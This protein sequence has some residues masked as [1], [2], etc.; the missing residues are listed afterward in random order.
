VISCDFGAFTHCGYVLTGMP[1]AQLVLLNSDKQQIGKDGLAPKRGDIVYIQGDNSQNMRDTMFAPAD[2][3][4]IITKGTAS[5]LRTFWKD[6]NPNKLTTELCID[7]AAGCGKSCAVKIL[8]AD[9][10][11]RLPETQVFYWRGTAASHLSIVHNKI[12]VVDKDT[13]LFFDQITDSTLARELS[14]FADRPSVR[15]VLV[16]SANLAHFA[17]HRE[18]RQHDK[19][20]HSFEFS[21]DAT[22]C[23]RYLS[24]MSP[25]SP[26]VVAKFQSVEVLGFSSRELPLPA[27]DDY[28]AVCCWTNGHLLSISQIVRGVTT[29]ETLLNERMN[30]MSDFMGQDSH[31]DFCLALLKMFRNG[32]TTLDAYIGS[33]DRRYVSPQRHVL[34][35]LFL[36]A[37]EHAL[38]VGSTKENL[39]ISNFFNASHMTLLNENPSVI[40]FAVERECLMDANLLRVAAGCLA[41][42]DIIV[43]R[44]VKC[45]RIGFRRYDQICDAA[46]KLGAGNWALHAIP[47]QWNEKSVDGVQLYSL[48]NNLYIIGN[49]ITLQTAQDH[50]HSVKWV[51]TA[52][53]M[54]TQLQTMFATVTSGLVFTAKQADDFTDLRI[55]DDDLLTRCAQFTV[56]DFPVMTLISAATAAYN[57]MDQKMT[58]VLAGCLWS[59]PRRGKLRGVVA[60]GAVGQLDAVATKPQ[61]NVH[62]IATMA[63]RVRTVRTSE[64]SMSSEIS[65]CNVV[66]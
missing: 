29:P 55:D 6:F 19:L 45:T 34:S 36:Q 43:D 35:P 13:I 27:A 52:L 33:F 37:F 61:R 58:M 42:L 20:V 56:F 62:P 25:G 7:G 53:E 2:H 8:V 11:R 32:K 40:G 48:K 50:V 4:Y 44:S 16:S 28:E 9:V 21:C 63:V 12:E 24:L 15:V 66:D 39:M 17:E 3:A 46:K 47:L 23:Q 18:G 30:M 64:D 31:F 60:K 22:D 10:C 41:T 49:S 26:P 51:E 57:K 1:K 5:L 59:E 65:G 38:V 54:S 14:I